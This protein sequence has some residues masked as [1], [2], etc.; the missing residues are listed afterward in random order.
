MI[1]GNPKRIHPFLF[2]AFFFV[3]AGCNNPRSISMPDAQKNNKPAAK[4]DPRFL[5]LSDIHLNT[6]SNTTAYGSD[7]GMELWANFL[8]KADSV[9]RSDNPPRFV[10]YTGDLPA[11]YSCSPSCYLPPEK[12]ATHNQNLKVIL[13]GLRNLADKYNIPLFYMPG[14]ND[15]LA[16][17]YYSFADEQQQTPFSLVPDTKNPYPALNILPGSAKAPCLVSNPHPT[18]GYYSAR[19]VE[20]LRLI[21]MNTII[22][23]SGFQAVDGTNQQTDGDA[24]MLWL[25]SQLAEARAQ[26][27]KVYI[28]MHIPP[29]TDAYSGNSMWVKLPGQITSWLN[30][31]LSLTTIYENTISGIL[32][33]HTHMDELRRLYDSTGTRITEVAISCPGVTPQHY[34]NPGF[35]TVTYDAASKELM[36]FTTHYTTPTATSW[37]NSS[38]SFRSTFSGKP[39]VSLFQQ[40]SNMPLTDI[41]HTLNNIFTVKNGL[42]TYNIQTG[43]EVKWNQ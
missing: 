3:A 23:N 10:V 17:D 26:N 24:Q 13:T 4:E 27:E 25:A 21:S 14:N 19:P 32:Y 42:P 22:Y 35:K 11:H 40:L 1:P 18:M 41:T 15:G 12:R 37:G 5:F 36:D 31:F 8:N 16:G 28:A 33:G 6:T 30:I 20:G 34:N 43:I 38:Y 9:L 2:A 7:T 29:G 39:G